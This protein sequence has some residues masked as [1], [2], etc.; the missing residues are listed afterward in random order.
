M[1]KA[2]LP[3][4]EQPNTQKTQ[5]LQDIIDKFGPITS[6]YY[7][8]FKCEPEQTARALLPPLF[9]RNAHQFDYF[10][11]FFTHD[12]LYTITTNTNRYANL[13]SLYI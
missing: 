7:K 5:S 1:K 13:Q 3:K 10:S 12:I 11:L 6:V 2:P 9:P 4:T 8:P